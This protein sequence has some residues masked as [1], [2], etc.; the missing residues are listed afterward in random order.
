MVRQEASWV[1]AT[2]FSHFGTGCSRHP[3]PA[4]GELT[5]LEK[6]VLTL[7]GLEGVAS[8]CYASV[9]L[10]VLNTNDITEAFASLEKRGRIRPSR[11]QTTR[12][13]NGGTVPAEHVLYERVR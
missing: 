5:A 2:E 7:I 3:R 4:A 8:P 1:Y 9:T 12:A 11:R 6:R 10:T 13:M